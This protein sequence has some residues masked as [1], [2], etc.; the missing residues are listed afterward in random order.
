MKKDPG[1]LIGYGLLALFAFLSLLID[2]DYLRPHYAFRQVWNLALLSFGVALLYRM[3]VRMR[4][5]AF[6]K[7]QKEY[8]ELKEK[9]E[10]QKFVNL[11]CAI[12]QLEKRIAALEGKR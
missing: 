6:E 1:M 2:L 7:L 5:G 3:R 10:E 4:S 8:N 9:S 11:R 12:E